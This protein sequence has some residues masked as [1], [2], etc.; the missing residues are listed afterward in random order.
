MKSFLFYVGTWFFLPRFIS[1]K[2]IT[3]ITG[4]KK[5]QAFFGK[6]LFADQLSKNS[7]AFTHPTCWEHQIYSHAQTT[8]EENCPSHWGKKIFISEASNWKRCGIEISKKKI[9]KKKPNKMKDVY[10]SHTNQSLRFTTTPRPL[11]PQKYN[12]VGVSRNHLTPHKLSIISP[13]IFYVFAL[14][15]LSLLFFRLFLSTSFQMFS[16]HILFLLFVVFFKLTS[17]GR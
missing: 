2:L 5:K 1:H 17:I 3:Y 12:L 9:I 11:W 15:L 6:N 10:K 14:T 4:I 8:S 13:C 16:L 7:F